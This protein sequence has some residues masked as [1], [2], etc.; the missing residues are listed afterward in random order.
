MKLKLLYALLVVFSFVALGGSTTALA[1]PT[2]D[3]FGSATAIL[4]LPFS[5]V[6]NTAGAT[7]EPGEPQP[8]NFMSQTVWYSFKPAT[9][10]VVTADNI[11]TGFV[12]DLNVYQQTGSGFGGLSFLGCSQNSNPVIFTAQA[13]T[14]YFIQTGILF[15]A[16]GDLHVNLHAVPPPPNDNF[17]NATPVASLP[18]TNTVDTTAATTEAGEPTPSCATFF[19]PTGTVWYSFTPPVSETVSSNIQA[20]FG[21]T[22]VAVYSGSSLSGL[23]ELGS[24]CFGGTLSVHL[25]GGTTYHFQ[26]AG[27]FGGRGSLTFNLFVTPPPNAS[28]FFSP[29]DPSIFD[30]VQ[31]TNNSADP[32]ELGFRPASWDFGDGTAMTT[33]TNPVSHQ[34]AKDG[35][36]TVKLTVTTVDGRTASTSQIVHVKTHDVAITKFIIPTSASPDQTRRITVGISDTRYPEAV[37]VQLFKSTSSGG[38]DLVGTLTQSVPLTTG[39][40]TTPFVFSYTFTSSDATVGKVTFEATATIQGARDA[41]PADNTAITSPTIVH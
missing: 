14:T 31:F 16:A 32:G 5:D 39:Q 27:L 34:Y 30:T 22:V 6:V 21:S 18:Y 23:S 1:V 26:A 10:Q 29:F 38:F 15:G 13:G 4:S 35:D 36:Y 11:G 41:V 33:N 9:T 28:F 40:S 8:C 25:N 2:N 19:N 24:A 7:T 12:T 37:Q 17:A 20:F 3:N